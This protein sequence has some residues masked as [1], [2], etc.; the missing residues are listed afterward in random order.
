MTDLTTR[1]QAFAHDAYPRYVRDLEAM[2]DIESE[3]GDVEGSA[4]IARLLSERLEAL[5][6]AVETR[7]NDQGT[8][9]IARLTGRG[10]TRSL[11]L[12]HTDTVY[13]RGALARQPFRV[14]AEGRAF[15]PGAGDSKASAVFA[16][17]VAE[18]LATITDRPFGEVCFYWDAEEETGS[19]D[20]RAIVRELAQAADLAIVLD[21]ARPGWGIVT[22]R[23]GLAR[24]DLCVRGIGGHAGNAP[25]ASASAVRELVSQLARLDAL[26]SPLPGD[27]RDFGRAAL[28]ERDIADR[29]QWIPAVSINA[30]VIGTS[31]TKVNV[32]PADAWAEIEVRAFARADLERVEAALRDQARQPA[33]AGTVVEVSGGIEYPPL[34]IGPEGARIIEAYKQIVKRTFGEDVVEWSAGGVTVG[35]FTAAQVPTVDALAVEMQHEHDLLR[36]FADLTTFGPRLVALVLL[37]EALSRPE[38][39][40][41]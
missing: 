11:L 21:T 13:P 2:V 14:D 23:K 39:G 30:G 33:T 10:G 9:V 17:H 24:Y 5:G 3:S 18:A 36:E 32:V 1:L 29:G 40:W 4:A 25:Q 38:E 27:P 12:M 6:A 31:N 35:N 34:E 7:S 37:I 16:L 41:A 22:R 8:H 28:A 19:A 26:A 15:G 20:E